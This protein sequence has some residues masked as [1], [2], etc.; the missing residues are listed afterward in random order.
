MPLQ[1]HH[2]TYYGPGKD[3]NSQFEEQFLTN[4]YDFQTM[5]KSKI[6]S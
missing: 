1:E 2:T 3:Q 6:V 4:A 5:A